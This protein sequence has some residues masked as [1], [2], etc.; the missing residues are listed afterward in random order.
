MSTVRVYVYGNVYYELAATQWL[1]IKVFFDDSVLFEVPAEDD[2]EELLDNLVIE[3][4]KTR[5]NKALPQLVLEDR[6]FTTD[7]SVHELKK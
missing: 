5:I 4:A 2:Y 6:K 3:A 1:E 7:F